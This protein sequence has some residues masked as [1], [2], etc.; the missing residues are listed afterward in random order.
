MPL[1]PGSKLGPYEILAPLGAGGM[2]EV[3]KARDTRL[4]R[5]VAIKVLL[6]SQVADAE[7]K[8]R[9]VQEAK[10]ASAL[11]HP[12]IVVLYDIACDNAID[13]MV[14]EY[15]SGKTLDRAIPSKGLR[16]GETLKYAIQMADALAKAH[17]AGIVH[18]DLKPG[19]IMV[20]DDGQVKVLDFGLAK[21]TER[22]AGVEEVTLTARP[23]TEEGAILGTIAYM[24]PEQA[25]G[26][27]VDSRSDIF[28]F[29]VVL[30][31][32]IAG[33]RPFRG[34]SKL[35]TMSAILRED[36]KPIVQLAPDIPLDLE[37]IVQRCLRKDPSRRFQHMA[38]LKVAL[39]EVKEESESGT[40]Q[41]APVV[42][43][44]KPKRLPGFAAVAMLGLIGA[45]GA[46]WQFS[47]GH[48]PAPSRT[49][50]F[51][52][53]GS[54]VYPAFSPDGKLIAFS[55]SGPNRDN[56]DI[57]VQQI[58]AGS[59]LRLTTDPGADLS[60]VFSPDGRY[61][62]FTRNGRALML[63]PVLGG[64]ERKLGMVYGSAID[65]SPDG[66]TIAVSDRASAAESLGIVLLSVET[67]EKRRLT[68][69]K[70]P[71]GDFQPKFSPDGQTIAFDRHINSQLNDIDTVPVNGGETKRLSGDNR[72]V[73]GLAWLPDG[74]QVVYASRRTGRPQ[75]LWI[76][77]ASG[78]TPQ[79]L[80][81]AGENA[82]GPAI[83]R[84]GNRLAYVRSIYDENIWRLDLTGDT[85]HAS[86][87]P[88][89]LI[90]STWMD[91]SPQ[92][93]PDAKKIAFAS[94]RSGG[95]E[96]WVCSADGSSPVQL[97]FLSGHSG[98]PRW[99]PDS[100]RIA[101]DSH[102]NGNA[103]IYVIDADGGAPRRFTT[104]PGNDTVPSWSSS[105]QWIY[106]TSDRTGRS[107][108]WREP[109]GGGQETQVTR[110]GGFDPR[111]SPDGKVLYYLKR[112]NEAAIWRV[113]PEGGVESIAV[114][115]VVTDFGWWQP[116]SDGIYLVQ[117]VAEANPVRHQ[118]QFL[119]FATGKASLIAVL[120][121]PVSGYGG[122]SVSP[123][124]RHLFVAQI[125]QNDLDIMLVEDFR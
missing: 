8:L 84:T 48:N 2:G 50:P 5:V 49:T 51:T 92:Y 75:E 78:G 121:K 59:P 37:K 71:T 38:D 114:E 87:E 40:S 33:Q 30:Y 124:R 122:F 112:R 82:S 100:R 31:E 70:S 76:V 80:S 25:E 120:A 3:Y 97:T 113:P 99:S 32:M 18:R 89:K 54:E 103:D 66:K 15:V 83:A 34:D 81:V 23:E 56:W 55:W 93:S 95:F 94:D 69:P 27:P 61:I 68:S 16:T 73:D 47:R 42:A 13:F 117:R 44:R 118:V 43:P 45:A 6:S 60:P 65:F 125:D 107:E 111:E 67:G 119:D 11:N 28:S 85:R 29:G 22:P 12:N 53:F 41:G 106:F 88:V 90:A 46:W 36:P 96:I 123:D 116:V 110:Q 35:S 63:V 52:S 9:F 98:T 24:S 86:G 39:L 26:R 101:F 21:L 4:D 7:R 109:V 17:A 105:G 72:A 62:A 58:G 77:N 115:S 57:Y 20:N 104:N 64:A 19:N 79:P 74:R 14:M 1:S 108:I 91:N 10:A 102:V